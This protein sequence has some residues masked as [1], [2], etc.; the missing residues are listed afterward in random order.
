[1][2]YHSLLIRMYFR[3]SKLLDFDFGNSE[4]YIRGLGL[5]DYTES[6]EAGA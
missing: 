4:C 5:A 1:M 3:W 2:Y 6:N